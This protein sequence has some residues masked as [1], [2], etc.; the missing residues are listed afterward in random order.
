MP[1]VPGLGVKANLAP[2]LALPF[3]IGHYEPYASLCA[4]AGDSGTGFAEHQRARTTEPFSHPYLE[5]ARERVV[6]FDGAMGTNIQLMG[7]TAD[8]FGGAELEGCNEVLVL[9]R[10]DAI[11]GLHREFLQAGVDVIET[12]TFGAFAPVLTEYGIADK[13]REINLEAAR[14]AR[15]AAQEFSTKDRPRWV[16]GSIGPGTKLPSLGQVS[17]GFLRDAYEVQATALLEGGVDLLLIETVYDLLQAKAAIAAARRA[18]AATGKRVPLQVQVTIETTGRMLPGTEI[19]AALCTLEA[20]GP[21]VIGMNCATGPTEMVEHL[22]YLCQ[23]SRLPVSA[24]PNAGLPSVKEGK[25]HYDLTPDQLAESHELLV[26]ELGVSVI[27]GCCGTTPAHLKAVVDRCSNLMPLE[28]HPEPEPGAASLYSHVPFHQEASVLI[29]GE[30]ANANGS[31]A[32]REAMLAGDWDRTL[33]IGRSQAREGA[34]LI[35]VCVDYTGADG[36]SNIGQVVS[37][38]A[39]QVSMPLVIDTTESEVARAALE[40]IGGRPVLN[41][42]NLEDGSGPGTRLD[43]FLSLAGEF[44]AA[45]VCTCID[46]EGQ[47]RDAQWKLRAARAICELAIERYGLRAEDLFVDPLVLPLTTGMEESRRD[48]IETIE[49]ISMIKQALPG[50]NTIIGLSNVSFG[51]HPAARQAL[52]SVFLQE[53]MNAGL[54]AAIMHAGRIVPIASLDEQVRQTCL[55][56][57]YDRRQS[58]YD[59]LAKLLELFEGADAL[60]S[61]RETHED[62]PVEKRLTQR[63]IDGDRNGLEADLDEALQA[64]HSALEIVNEYLLAGMAVV[65]ERFGKGEMQLPFVLQS[66]EAMKAAVSYLE[67]HMPKTGEAGKGTV[68]LATVK[69]DVHDIGK[70]LVDIILSNNG[71]KVVN[72]GIKV[73]LS[74]MLEAFEKERAD[75]IGMSGLLVKS[76]LVMRENLEELNR[77]ER[78][79]IP[80]IL[81]GAALTRRFVEQDLRSLYKGRVF[82]GRDAF[83]GL[84]VM[85]RLVPILRGDSEDPDF[86]RQ[87]PESPQSERRSERLAKIDPSSIP[88][89]S[90]EV[91]RDNPV[92]VPPFSGSRIAKGMS[93]EEIAEFLNETA[94][95][96]NQWGFRPERGEKDAEFK[97]RIRPVLREQLARAKEGGYLVPQVVWGYFPVGSD[98][99]ELVVFEADERTKPADTKGVDKEL[100]R[101]VFPR[102]K[103]APWLCIADFFR[104][105]DSG[106]LDWLGLFVVTMGQEVTKAAHQLF[107]TGKYNDYLR[108]HGL[109][110]EMTEALAEMWHRRMREEW[111]F[112]EEDGP[113]LSGLFRQQYRGGRYSFGYPACPD[114]SDNAKVVKLLDASRIGVETPDGEQLEPEQTTLAIVC[115]HPQAKYFVV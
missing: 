20:L 72:L 106:E 90:P 53:C 39:S 44:G 26:T 33:E 73:P 10:P 108:V 82:Y 19:Q 3:S 7:L 85:E 9:S 70:N 47:A 100:T 46:E 5:A 76:T 101:F 55:D 110:V 102:Q 35:D 114:L 2:L 66:A 41:S 21:D 74:E 84:D 83:E 36:V 97:Q 77:L 60:S 86:G 63:I 4:M 30:R 54:D 68:L 56:L 104:P 50:V 89:R 43:S 105:V 107:E 51:L 59:P 27:G 88:R 58:D 37:R 65:G 113:T 111:G 96:R 16:A 14:I 81:G 71:Y 40:L 79:D 78:Q 109:G 25:M 18:M 64:G 52:N 103:E 31:R 28:R 42:V 17:Y 22:R 69:G 13:T 115:H 61:K 23:H 75:V 32:F 67:P 8:D 87:V 11:A 80:V 49:A 92:F 15:E 48:G 12:D 1:P 99:D 24:I 6:I 34:H 62:W 29:V 95:F 57:I 45:V 94:L 93:L 38:M 112:A 98:G 91:A